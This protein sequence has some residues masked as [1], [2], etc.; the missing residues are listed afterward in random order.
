MMNMAIFLTLFGEINMGKVKAIRNE[1][2]TQGIQSPLEKQFTNSLS[3]I[4]ENVNQARL[5]FVYERAFNTKRINATWY[6]SEGLSQEQA[7]KD[8]LKL[9]SKAAYFGRAVGGGWF[10]VSKD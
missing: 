7:I 9:K 10:G 2:S 5:G 6:K 8:G 1:P 3:K 4:I